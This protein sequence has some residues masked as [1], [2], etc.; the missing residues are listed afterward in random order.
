MKR[1]SQVGFAILNNVERLEEIYKLAGDSA[2]SA[3]EEQSK[4]LQGVQYQIDNFQASVEKLSNTFMEADFL[5]GVIS[6]GT[7][8]IDILDVIIDKL[9]TIPLIFG[10][11]GGVLSSKGVGMNGDTIKGIFGLGEINE[12]KN[13]LGG[14][15]SDGDLKALDNFA[16]KLRSG[17]EFTVAFKEELAGASENARQFALQFEGIEF[18]DTR[19][20]SAEFEELDE[21]T[22]QLNLSQIAASHTFSDNARLISIYNNRVTD[23]NGVTTYAGLSQEAW[24]S[25]LATSNTA[26]ARY[27]AS[28][29]GGKASMAGYVAF[30][31]KATA[32]QVA[33]QAAAMAVQAVIGMGL[34]LVISAVV[35]AIDSWIHKTEKL[36]EAGEKAKN[37]IAEIND[38]LKS[39]QKLITD[40]GQRFAELS[41]G[42]NQVT[43][44]NISLTNED[45]QEFLDI[46][47]ELANLFPSL[48]RHYDENGNA[49]VDLDG[50]V[51]TIT[52]SLRDL[53][54]VQEDLARRKI[55]DEMPNAIEGAYASVESQYQDELQ[56]INDE[57]DAL[58]LRKDTLKEVLE[59]GNSSF[60]ILNT[61][62]LDAFRIKLRELGLAFEEFGDDVSTTFVIDTDTILDPNTIGQIV[63]VYDNQYSRLQAELEK[64]INSK[65]KA[66]STS[67]SSSIAAWL[68]SPSENYEYLQYSAEIQSQI[69]D[70]I[71]NIDWDSLDWKGDNNLLLELLD[72]NVLD[73]FKDTGNRKQLETVFSLKAESNNKDISVQDYL[74]Q[75]D[76]IKTITDSIEDETI[77]EA[78]LVTLGIEFDDSENTIYTV[79]ENIKK[80]MSKVLG[81][82]NKNLI[83]DL[84]NDLSLSDLD[85]LMDSDIDWRR[86]LSIDGYDAQLAYI[87]NQALRLSQI[88]FSINFNE[89]SI[90]NATDGIAEFQKV[91]QTVFEQSQEGTDL[92]VLYSDLDSI[93]KAFEEAGI[94]VEQLGDTWTDFK[95]AITDGSHSFEEI[96]SA[97]NKV[98]TAYTNATIDLENFDREQADAIATQL[99][100]AGVTKESAEAYVESKL[101]Q[102]EAIQEVEKETESWIDITAED[103]NA[104]AEE[105]GW[106]ESVTATLAAH[107]LQKQ[108]VNGITINTSGDIQNLINLATAAGITTDRL[109]QL[110][111][112]K[113]NLDK[114]YA[115]FVQDGA[116]EA[117]ASA[118]AIAK[119][120]Y[121][122][123]KGRAEEDVQAQLNALKNNQAVNLDSSKLKDSSKSG[124]GSS[125]KEE[126]LW[127]KQYEEELKALEHLHEMELITDIDFYKEKEKLNDKY[128]KDNEKYS[129]DY[130]KNQEDIYKGLKSAYQTWVDETLNYYKSAL[131]SGDMTLQEYSNNVL[132][133]LNQVHDLGFIDD[134]IYHQQMAQYYGNIVEQ[135]DKATN[136]AKR[137]IAKEVERL[138]NEKDA[139]EKTY[140][141]KKQAIQDEI[142]AIQ[143][144]IDKRD[145]QKEAIN[146]VIEGKNKEIKA[147]NKE[148]KAKNKQIEAINKEIKAKNKQIDVINKDIKGKNKQ[149]D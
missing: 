127:K 7:E 87:K 68:Y 36:I 76:G 59:G 46:S 91:Y 125:K 105:K 11:I 49:I 123:I 2:G 129:E 82:E 93:T 94:T 102:A 66:F 57:L 25:T 5:K 79:A 4:Y 98:V 43:G 10:T 23:A 124:G 103:I 114:A 89:Q 88:P 101:A 113:A 63:D 54:E 133:Y 34:G 33:L 99:Q 136:A 74:S 9:G 51:A 132:S 70:I 12:N 55:L 130:A 19:S 45:Y 62:D 126:D 115:D 29:N 52:K 80:Q 119:Q 22:R 143:A 135:Y 140:D 17:K 142:D 149:I 117:E 41:Q 134:Q 141:D 96:E 108:T 110:A 1:N 97:L 38:S 147:I 86:I 109:I 58:K 75:L 112:A 120:S 21:S 144:E 26:M 15:I 116:T 16:E 20:L 13:L 35:K 77:R 72:K 81:K 27:I 53:Y 100:L 69:Q 84:V 78:F 71:N 146:E 138:E 30:T 104:L 106:T 107:A 42:I 24:N 83:D 145:E 122:Y 18:D 64:V 56:G 44:E 137:V 73:V 111:A 40:S 121:N 92:G 31:I 39:Q 3:M 131:D 32:A 28:L 8:F 65:N 61:D 67:I 139:L 14:I 128:F 85:V 148:I 60:T 47:N 6:V 118:L 37:T 95:D 50:D 48:S 90:K